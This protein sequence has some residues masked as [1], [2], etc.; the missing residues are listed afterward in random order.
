MGVPYFKNDQ[1]FYGLYYVFK[2]PL[3][4]KKDRTIILRHFV[5]S[6]DST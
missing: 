2:A 5:Y 4:L 1:D 3:N 6:I